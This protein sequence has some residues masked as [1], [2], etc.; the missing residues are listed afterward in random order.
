MKY[1]LAEYWSESS[2]TRSISKSGFAEFCEKP[3]IQ[4]VLATLSELKDIFPSHLSETDRLA[5]PG[6]ALLLQFEF[7][8]PKT[9]YAIFE[10]LGRAEFAAM[11]RKR[12]VGNVAKRLDCKLASFSI[13]ILNFEI[14]CSRGHSGEAE[15]GTGKEQPRAYN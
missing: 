1:F 13:R 3:S 8:A 4:P 6:V 2:L 12:V 11:G 7:G 10:L 9:V 15:C 5:R 14:S